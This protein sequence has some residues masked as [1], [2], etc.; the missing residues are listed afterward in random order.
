MPAKNVSLRYAKPYFL[1][2]WNKKFLASFL[3]Q[4]KLCAGLIPT[5]FLKLGRLATRS[6]CFVEGSYSFQKM[7]WFVRRWYK[8]SANDLIFRIFRNG[9]IVS[10]CRSGSVDWRFNGRDFDPS[11]FVPRRI[12]VFQKAKVSP[13]THITFGCP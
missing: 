1:M 12:G 10:S 2:I 5:F 7:R 4:R 3:F 11:L 6:C 8:Y 13:I 9:N